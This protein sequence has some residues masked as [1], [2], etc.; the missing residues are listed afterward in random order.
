MPVTLNHVLQVLPLSELHS[1][2]EEAHG[3]LLSEVLIHIL[4]QNGL[5]PIYV[6]SYKARKGHL[7]K[8]PPSL[9]LSTCLGNKFSHS[10]STKMKTQV[11]KN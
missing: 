6:S 9:G 11:W 10:Q 2:L 4:T 8:L 5:V 7:P 3:A 1:L